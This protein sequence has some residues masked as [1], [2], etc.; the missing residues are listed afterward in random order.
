[1]SLQDA[2]SFRAD[3]VKKYLISTNKTQFAILLDFVR[4]LNSSDAMCKLYTVIWRELQESGANETMEALAVWN[5]VSD[6][7]KPKPK[8]NSLSSLKSRPPCSHIADSNAPAHRQ[9]FFSMYT[10]YIKNGQTM[11]IRNLHQTNRMEY[12]F[13]DYIKSL[14]SNDFEDNFIKLLDAINLLPYVADMCFATAACSNKMWSNS[15]EHFRLLQSVKNIMH[16]SEYANLDKVSK[17]KCES[18]LKS[19]PATFQQLLN[20]TTSNCSLLNRHYDLDPLLCATSNSTEQGY[21]SIYLGTPPYGDAITFWN[22][23]VHSAGVRLTNHVNFTL[24]YTIYWTWRQYY[25]K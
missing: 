16:K 14:R 24:R 6:I 5:H 1:L 25:G 21:R 18:V 12:I 15:F 20:G 23:T 11:E 13:A 17:T 3:L 9:T 8:P 4:I 2:E 22:L 7:V 19:I 10:D